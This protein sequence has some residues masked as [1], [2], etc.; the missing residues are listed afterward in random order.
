M[1]SLV[2]FYF[3]YYFL[4]LLT[5]AE[6]LRFLGDPIEVEIPTCPLTHPTPV[7]LNEN[8]DRFQKELKPVAVSKRVGPVLTKAT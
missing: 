1:L 2:P 6:L 4:A 3:T 8:R 7:H 5:T